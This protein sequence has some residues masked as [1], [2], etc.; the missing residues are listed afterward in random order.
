M[1]ILRNKPADRRGFTLIEMIVVMAIIALLV[2]LTVAAV[3]VFS[4]TA[5]KQDRVDIGQMTSALQ[6]FKAKFGF[7]PP[8]RFYVCNTRANYYNPP[9]QPPNLPATWSAAQKTAFTLATAQQSLQTLNRMFPQIVWT[10][11]NGNNAQA[12]YPPVP[13][14]QPDNGYWL[15]GDQCLVFFLGGLPGPGPSCQGFST[16][17][18][19]PT[20]GGG[21]RIKFYE[22][23]GNRLVNRGGNY[24][25]SYVNPFGDLAQ[26]Y[27]YLCSFGGQNRYNS[28]LMN[29]VGVVD[30]TLNPQGVSDCVSL[31]VNP[32]ATFWPAAAGQTVQFINPDS[33]QLISAGTDG[34]FGPGTTSTTTIWSASSPTGDP[35]GKDDIS[36]FSDAVLGAG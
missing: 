36:N 18:Q 31:G 12:W 1:S 6:Q 21:E 11:V 23:K 2:S 22:F 27:A 24:F 32:Y 20:A 10:D 30:P 28:L 26:P 16:N 15:E 34:V 29:N 9:I 8:S 35:N 7:Y 19:V 5:P 17:K 25:F 3:M 13:A 4:N 33:F 14:G